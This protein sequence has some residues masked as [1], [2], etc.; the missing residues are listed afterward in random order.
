VIYIV[1][2]YAAKIMT[3][4]VSSS[5]LSAKAIKK[6]KRPDRDH[7]SSKHQLEIVPEGNESSGL[8]KK[9]RKKDKDGDNLSEKSEDQERKGGTDESISKMDGRLLADHFMQRSRKLNKELTAIKLNDLHIPGEVT[10]I[11]GDPW[12]VQTDRQTRASF[13]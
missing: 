8:S 7:A 12:A 1:P 11:L 6:R 10:I 13:P 3:E 2:I 5:G 9:R 4:E